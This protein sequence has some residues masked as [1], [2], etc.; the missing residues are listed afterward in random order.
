MKH[1]TATI[2]NLPAIAPIRRMLATADVDPGIVRVLCA[3]GAQ[4]EALSSVP[5]EMVVTA[6]DE[7]TAILWDLPHAAIRAAL[8]EGRDPVLVVREW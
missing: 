7:G 8:L 1:S 5:S 2:A 6:A 4:V 3:R